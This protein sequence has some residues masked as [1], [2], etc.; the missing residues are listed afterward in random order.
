[1]VSPDCLAA[2]DVCALRVARLTAAGIPR[3]GSG[4]GYVSDSMIQAKIGTTN[5]T[6]NEV[7]RRNGCGQIITH[8]PQIVSVK[9]STISFDLARWDRALL[10][11]LVG[12]I[13]MLDSGHNSGYRAPFLTDGPPDPVCIEV[14]SRAWD[15]SKQGVTTASTPNVSYHHYVMPF[16]QC[17]MSEF[18][19]ASGD[20]VF[21]VTGEGSENSSIT[22]DGP[23]NDWPA[24]VA[25]HGGFTSAFGEYDDGTIPTAACGATTLPATS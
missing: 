2:V 15:G 19:L 14:W 21:T 12:G 3:A 1:M 24:W 9:G 23:W 7:L 5:D 11:M 6:V 16:V 4:N 25:G 20:A 10:A 8:V 22:A 18:T 17:S 13:V